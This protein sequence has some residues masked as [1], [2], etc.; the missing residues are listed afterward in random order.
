VGHSYRVGST[1]PA[2]A[3]IAIAIGTAPAPF[4]VVT[5]DLIG[6]VLAIY[7]SIIL[8]G[9]YAGFLGKYFYERPRRRD[10]D[11]DKTR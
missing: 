2:H 3:F 7:L 11:S 4:E 6:A 10:D 8:L 1:A 5:P 9:L